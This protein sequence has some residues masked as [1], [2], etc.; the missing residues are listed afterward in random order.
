MAKRRTG[1]KQLPEAM[2]I[3]FTDAYKLMRY[4]ATFGVPIIGYTPSSLR[5]ISYK[6]MCI[7][8]PWTKFTMIY[9]DKVRGP[10]SPL[11]HHHHFI[12]KRNYMFS[13]KL[14]FANDAQLTVSI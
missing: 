14:R 1:N 9:N 13:R 11:E 5:A 3:Q 10:V 8:W 2:L 12:T 7:T 4:D 6:Y